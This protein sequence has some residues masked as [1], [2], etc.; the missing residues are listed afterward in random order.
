MKSDALSHFDL[1][2]TAAAPRGMIQVDLGHSQQHPPMSA[3]HSTCVLG[4]H[5]GIVVG[6]GA[7]AGVVGVDVD[8]AVGGGGVDVGM[9]LQTLSETV[10]IVKFV[11]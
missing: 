11:H 7:V 3:D 6:G 2:E 9:P 1:L 5:T 4:T 10:K 8:V